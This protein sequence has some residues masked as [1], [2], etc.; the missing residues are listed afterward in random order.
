MKSVGEKATKKWTTTVVIA[1]FG[2]SLG[3]AGEARAADVSCSQNT[4]MVKNI[5][6]YTSHCT[7]TPT[8]QGQQLTRREVKR[9]TLT[10]E[11]AEDHLNIA[12]YYEAEA[13][14]LEAQAAGYEETVASYR[15]N[16]A[17][18]NLMSP[19]AAAHY[20]Y[21][22]RGFREEAKADRTLA[23]S[24]E[25]MAKNT[26]AQAELPRASAGVTQ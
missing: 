15:R 6:S 14:K 8:I 21:Q 2:L 23:A 9:L 10:A 16:P 3:A 22:A 13:D 24:Q 19:T 7:G 4:P 26:V 11:S 18:K 5:R 12:R 17:P 25:Q 20:E 1:L